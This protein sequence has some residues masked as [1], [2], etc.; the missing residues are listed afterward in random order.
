MWVLLVNLLIKQV[1]VNYAIPRHSSRH[2]RCR[3][4]QDSDGHNS[5]G[6]NIIERKESGRGW[7]GTKM[8]KYKNII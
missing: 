5:H 6:P 2:W 8:Y 4:E 1:F 7:K 3:D